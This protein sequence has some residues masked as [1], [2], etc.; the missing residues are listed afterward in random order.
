[1]IRRRRCWKPSATNPERVKHWVVLVDG[2]ETQLDLVEASAAE[3]GVDVTVIVLV[4]VG[5][6]DN[7]LVFGSSL[8]HF[9]RIIAAFGAFSGSII[10]F[11]FG[12]RGAQRKEDFNSGSTG[13]STPA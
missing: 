6:F 12:T 11:Y 13:K 5:S 9:D 3:F 10:S 8:E 2:A 1:M 4:I 7:V